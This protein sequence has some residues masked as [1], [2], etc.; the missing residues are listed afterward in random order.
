[1]LQNFLLSQ[2]AALARR[3]NKVYFQQDSNIAQ[4]DRQGTELVRSLFHR[5]IPRFGDIPLP[6]T[7]PDD[8]GFPSRGTLETMYIQEAPAHKTGAEA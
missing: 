8:R 6:S 3:S 1:M 4:I 7:S 5:V 2:L